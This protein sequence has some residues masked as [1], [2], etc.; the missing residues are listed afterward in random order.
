M[1]SKLLR[2]VTEG[3]RNVIS[4]C[5][6]CGSTLF[7]DELARPHV[8]KNGNNDNVVCPRVGCNPV[9]I[10]VPPKCCDIAEMNLVRFALL[11]L[12]VPDEDAKSAAI[13]LNKGKA[14]A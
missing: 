11:R 4:Y 8:L 5:T 1:S 7:W 2:D 3:W 6:Q 12:G 10:N 13:L 14:A 9:L